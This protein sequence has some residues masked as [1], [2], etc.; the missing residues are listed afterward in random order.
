[1]RLL[2]GK[3]LA[4]FLKAV[5]FIVPLMDAEYAAYYT[6]EV[7]AILV[8]EFATPDEEMK[9]IVLKASE[10]EG[11]W[12]GG[13]RRA[14]RGSCLQVRE[15]PHGQQKGSQIVGGHVLLQALARLHL[16]GCAATASTAVKSGRSPHIS[17]DMKP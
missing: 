8:R 7:M 10:G 17:P 15:Q 12:V 14:H 16:L 6:R 3:V 5:G 4:A 2:R 13:G 1:M 11:V 9:K